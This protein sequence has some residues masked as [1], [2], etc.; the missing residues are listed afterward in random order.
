[1]GEV[2]SLVM[3]DHS[4]TPQTGPESW[5]KDSQYQRTE[6]FNFGLAPCVKFVSPISGL[7]SERRNGR[8]F[9]GKKTIPGG[10]FRGGM[11]KD[12]TFPFFFLEP[13]PNADQTI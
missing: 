10:D 9:S 1:M 11:A 12:H 3:S 7:I 8:I 2:W 13:F 5:E 4:R 6:K